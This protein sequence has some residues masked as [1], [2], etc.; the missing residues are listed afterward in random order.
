MPY[1]T[2]NNILEK[3]IQTKYTEVAAA[4]LNISLDIIKELALNYAKNKTTRNFIA[5]IKYKHNQGK[6]AVIAEIKQASPSKGILCQNFNPSKIALQY[7]QYGASCLSILTD[8]TYFKG[9]AT[10]IEQCKNV[11]KLPILRKDFIIDEY[12][13]YESILMG[14][15]AILLIASILDAQTMQKFESIANS[16]NLAVLPEIH[17]TEE[18]NKAINLNTQLLGINNRNLSSFEVNLQQTI[19]LLPYIKH[20]IV[21]TESGILTTDD[22]NL[23][24][25]NNV[26]TFLV[27]EAFMKKPH[28]GLALNNIFG[29]LS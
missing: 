23:M 13:I 17:H 5:A 19:E 9:D 12:Q 11:C 21:V 29:E 8:K 24:R 25:S 20:K 18:L 14:A 28:P 2:N 10:F 4:K 26:N 16:L 1:N 3:I 6:S 7:E 27:G 22:V 15:D